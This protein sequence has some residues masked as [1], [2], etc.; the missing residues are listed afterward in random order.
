[1]AGTTDQRVARLFDKKYLIGLRLAWLLLGILGAPFFGDALHD[2][3]SGFRTATSLSLWVLWFVGLVLTLVP[4]PLTLTGIRLLGVGAFAAA[5]WASTS[6]QIGAALVL[7]LG[8]TALASGMTLLPQIAARF[9]D[10]A[11]YGPE[12][13]LPLKPPAGVLVGPLQLTVV[14]T[15]LGAT[16]GPLLL[17]TGRWLIGAI[18]TVVGLAVAAL[19][20]R[21]LHTL[22]R[23]WI[24]FVPAGFVLHDFTA[25]TDPVL[26]R[27]EDIDVVGPAFA[28][29]IAHDLTL[30][31]SGLAVEV[32]FE[33]PMDIPVRR[34]GNGA[35]MKPLRSL[36]F[37]PTQPGEVL[38]EAKRRQI[39]VG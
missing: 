1:M 4:H 18:L 33:H 12:R 17:F 9:V 30:G 36:L 11:S 37:S 27:R 35:E 29:S 24:V 6:S 22:A 38:A 32:R 39:N 26:L 14:L 21:S 16:A 7:G 10:G 2:T 34:G 8:A 15:L 19:G 3:E 20:F 28:D 13:R 5:V 25:L 23:R 31:S